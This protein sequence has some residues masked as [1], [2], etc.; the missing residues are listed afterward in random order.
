MGKQ[1]KRLP[2][3]LLYNGVKLKVEYDVNGN[4]RAFRYRVNPATMEIW[5]DASGD[6]ESTFEI[7]GM[8]IPV[9]GEKEMHGIIDSLLERQKARRGDDDPNH[10]IGRATQQR[11][12]YK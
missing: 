5:M 2:P 3:Y 1:Q 4:I 11:R 6:G 10:V 9:R 8:E 7:F 12:R